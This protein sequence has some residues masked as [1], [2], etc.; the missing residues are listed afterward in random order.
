MFQDTFELLAKQKLIS[1]DPIKT[2]PVHL[3]KSTIGG[4]QS[5]PMRCN[6]FLI[7]LFTHPPNYRQIICHYKTVTL[8]SLRT[9]GFAIQNNETS[10]AEL[11]RSLM[12]SCIKS[13]TVWYSLPK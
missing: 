5:I 9:N 6:P 3:D 8:F 7:N 10:F 2:M 1:N 11:S 12:T 4:F 13:G